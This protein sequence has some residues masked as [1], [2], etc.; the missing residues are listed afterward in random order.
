MGLRGAHKGSLKVS[1]QLPT[2]VEDGWDEKIPKLWLGYTMW[3]QSGLSALQAIGTANLEKM[4]YNAMY[5]KIYLR[6][7]EYRDDVR[8]FCKAFGSKLLLLKEIIRFGIRWTKERL[9]LKIRMLN[10]TQY[11]NR[12]Q[13]SL[14]QAKDIVDTCYD[15]LDLNNLKE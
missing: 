15:S 2:N 10:K 14:I 1:E 12:N 6:Y 8:S 11:I 4:N 3:P 5:A 7:P 13:M 9:S